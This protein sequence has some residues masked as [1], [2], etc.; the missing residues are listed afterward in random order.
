MFI[1]LRWLFPGRCLDATIN[2]G[3]C[4]FIDIMEVNTFE[5]KFDLDDAETQRFAIAICLVGAAVGRSPN[6]MRQYSLRW[7][8]E[9][10]TLSWSGRNTNFESPVTEAA[11]YLFPP[12]GISVL[13]SLQK[14]LRR[15]CHDRSLACLVNENI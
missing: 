14:K 11:V 10:V 1:R 8:P 7:Y 5:I 4:D 15:L 2:R 9:G 6:G 12:G 3:C 13:T